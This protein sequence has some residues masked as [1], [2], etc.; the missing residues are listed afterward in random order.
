MLQRFQVNV[1]LMGS[2]FE[3]IVLGQNAK[4]GREHLQSAIEEI[5]RIEALLTEFTTTSQ[6]ALINQFAGIRPVTVDTEVY[7][8]IQRCL[9]LSRL[10]QGS[11]DISAGALK[12]LY[13]FRKGF[14]GFPSPA[15]LKEVRQCVGYTNIDLLANNQVF[16]RKKG[17]CIGFGAIG[18]GYAAD[19][20]KALLVTRGVQH[21]VINASGDLTAWGTQTDGMPWKVGI[22]DPVTSD[23]IAYW[24]PIT[25]ASVATSGNYEQ[26]FDYQGVRYAHNLDPRSGLPTRYLKSVTVI[27]SSA[28]LSDAL[29]TVVTV[30]GVDIGIQL[31]DQLPRTHCLLINDKNQ[32][33]TSAALVIDT[34]R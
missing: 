1:R 33:F 5:K 27:S 4:E 22:T 31:I 28:E 20:A 10:S 23:R 19:R 9:A 13:N 2:A 15:Q 30:T 32:I 3:L 12:Q 34:I 8:L 17:M 21:G 29:A 16:L 14:S 11:F 25:N 24:L 6:T 18:K 7:Q 26:Y